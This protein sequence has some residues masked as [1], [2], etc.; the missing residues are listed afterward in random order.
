MLESLAAAEGVKN[1]SGTLTD[2]EALLKSDVLERLDRDHAGA[3]GIFLFDP[4]VDREIGAYL[5]AG[6]LDYD[7]GTSLMV[8]F[9]RSRS[10]GQARESA[11]TGIRV[12]AENPT[13]A[14]ARALFPT[15]R[16]VL[17]G[18]VF[19]PRMSRPGEAIYIPVDTA[20]AGDR[21]RARLRDILAIV[22]TDGVD[23]AEPES[24]G[25]MAGLALA[26][27]SIPYV[28]SGAVGMKERVTVL[29]MA[30]WALRRD[31]AGYI[32]PAVKALSGRG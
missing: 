19:L 8:L 12:A 7:A 22:G 32:L 1:F 3:F 31:L 24:F 14:F 6:A 16:L 26:R 13:T 4:A 21:L 11:A 29:L 5:D 10:A 17:P 28:K 9:E 30:V 2:P 20:L 27:N 23:P 15:T 18:I 25:T